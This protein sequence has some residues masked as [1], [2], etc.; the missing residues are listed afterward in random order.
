MATLAARLATLP[1]ASGAHGNTPPSRPTASRP[2]ASSTPPRSFRPPT[3]AAAPRPSPAAR[4][5]P[6]AGACRGQRP[7]PRSAQA[8]PLTQS[9]ST[10]STRSALPVPSRPA[11]TETQDPR[12]GEPA[13]SLHRPDRVRDRPGIWLAATGL[14]PGSST[15]HPRS[16]ASAEMPP[17]GP[18]LRHGA[19]ASSGSWTGQAEWA[20]P[21]CRSHEPGECTKRGFTVWDGH[22]PCELAAREHLRSAR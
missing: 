9:L 12:P 1:I 15:V 21:S 13:S 17:A 20:S 19:S 7:F 8:A 18:E 22:V 6:L 16:P 3:A 11:G 14:S 10:G 5:V 4:A 2:A